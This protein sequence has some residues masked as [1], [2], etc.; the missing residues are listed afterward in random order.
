MVPHQIPAL[1]NLLH[2][3]QVESELDDE[4][5]SYV[6]AVTDEKIQPLA[7]PPE[8][9]PAAARSP[10][11]AEPSTSS[12]QSGTAAL[13]RSL[14][15]SA[16]TF[17]SE[18]ASYAAIPLSPGPQSSR[19]RLASARQPQFFPQSTR[20]CCARFPYQGSRPADVYLPAHKI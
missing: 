17:V 12:R 9:K 19:L 2:T 10:N 18:F 15:P 3:R 20:C 8:K 5:A 16:R 14:S 7:S 1:R 13:A 4:I 6:A 11:V